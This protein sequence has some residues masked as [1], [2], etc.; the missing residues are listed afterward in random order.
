MTRTSQRLDGKSPDRAERR[1]TAEHLAARALAESA[2]LAEA[3]PKVLQTICDALDWEHGA[4]W[5]VD[6]DAEVLRCVETWHRPDVE[7]PEFEAISR[8]TMSRRGV[9]LPGRVWA[10]RQPAWIPDVT[11]DNNFPRAP[12]A[13]R[14]GLH[15]AFGFPI[16]IKDRVVGVMEFFSREIRE[17]DEDLLQMLATVGIQMGQVIERR[18]AEEELDRFFTLSLDMLCVAGF[19]GYFKRLN[20]AWERVLGYTRE[21]LLARP[22]LDF[23]HPVTPRW[24]RRTS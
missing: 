16:L 7:F 21:E 5:N 6:L 24:P 13:G 12:I 22:Y 3:T 15:A 11:Q 2:T 9:G 19:D 1:L 4:L 8:T 10:S 23:I 18:R 20:P 14:E 17:P